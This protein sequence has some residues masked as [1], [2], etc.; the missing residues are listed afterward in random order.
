MKRK[1]KSRDRLFEI[2]RNSFSKNKQV[3]NKNSRHSSKSKSRSIRD[4]S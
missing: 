3:F 4:N 1:L 2:V